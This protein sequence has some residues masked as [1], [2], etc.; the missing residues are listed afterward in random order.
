MKQRATYCDSQ[1]KIKDVDCYLLDK[2][3]EADFTTG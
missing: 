1:G 3:G 2:I